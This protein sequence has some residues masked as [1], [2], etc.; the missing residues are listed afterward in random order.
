MRIITAEDIEGRPLTEDEKGWLRQR[1]RH[2]EVDRNEAIHGR[3]VQDGSD[4]LEFGTGSQPTAPIQDD[5][6]DNYDSWKIKELK[7]EGEGRKPA[8]DFTGCTKKEDYVLA[9][10]AWD[11]E[12]PEDET[13]K[14]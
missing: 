13:P 11:L 10:R 7:E 6:G 5:D 3:R 4:E 2:A 9:L 8:V 12:H 1:D 14:E